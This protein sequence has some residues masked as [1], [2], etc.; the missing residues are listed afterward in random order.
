ML[1]EEI[2]VAAMETQIDLLE[3]NYSIWKN[4]NN[5]RENN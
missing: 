2:V 5:A 3:V 4:T 1:C